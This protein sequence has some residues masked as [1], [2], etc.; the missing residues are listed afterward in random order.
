MVSSPG[1]AGP[2]PGGSE[3]AAAPAAPVEA[4]MFLNDRALRKCS[5]RYDKRLQIR[6]V[7]NVWIQE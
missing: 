4:A 3:E 6:H 1:A 7:S 5:R 2:G